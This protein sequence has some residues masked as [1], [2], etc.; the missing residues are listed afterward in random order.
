MLIG[1][2]LKSWIYD[3]DVYRYD[4]IYKCKKMAKLVK[5]KL[6]VKVIFLA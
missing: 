3:C 4:N 6:V 2:W 5:D 1:L